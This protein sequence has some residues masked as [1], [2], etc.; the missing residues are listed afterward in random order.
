MV[1]PIGPKD[2]SSTPKVDATKVKKD[3]QKNHTLEAI[4]QKA[5]ERFQ[6]EF[7]RLKRPSKKDE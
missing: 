4:Q 3:V 2:I 5:K 1:N 7:E 6:A